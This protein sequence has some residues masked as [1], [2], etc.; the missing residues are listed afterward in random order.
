MNGGSGH[1]LA[2]VYNVRPYPISL[3]FGL[4][5]VWNT[6]GLN[7]ARQGQPGSN[8]TPVLEG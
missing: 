6:N 8:A 7:L 3:S 4:P 5:P 1:V 2:G